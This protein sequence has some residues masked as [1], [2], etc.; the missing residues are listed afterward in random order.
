MTIGNFDGVHLGHLAILNQ[1]KQAADDRN[2][3]SC[4]MSFEPLPQEYF[5][6]QNAPPR[7]YRIRDKWRALNGCQNNGQNHDPK[8]NQIDYFLCC[9][10]NRALASLSA[11]E[12]IHK[13]LLQQLN[14]KY[15]LVGDD[16]RFGHHRLGDFETL[17]AAG[18]QHGFEV[19]NSPSH[20]FNDA[21]VSS[22]RIRQALMDDQLQLASD[23]LG[24]PYQICGC[25]AHGDKRGRTIGFPTANIK[26]HRHSTAVNGVYAVSLQNEQGLC[27]E[28]VANIGKRPTVDGQNLQ[29]E[30]HLFDFNDEIYGQQVCVEFKQKIRSEKRFDSFDELKQQIIHDSKQA[31]DYFASM[32]TS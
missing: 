18:K 6:P 29:L 31:K 11:E 4:I 8:S 26:L 21:R 15:C 13:I 1:L 3:A 2:I 10:F 7:L 16:F 28:G 9:K 19:Y 12:F 22:T 14:V 25:V 5:S 23:M 17:K 32:K 24:R 30:V 20:C 27:F